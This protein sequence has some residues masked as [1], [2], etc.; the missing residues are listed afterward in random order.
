MK[1]LHT[2][3]WQLGRPYARIADADKRAKARAARFDALET[4]VTIAQDHAVSL[5]VV[6]GDV[7]DAPTVD[8]ATVSRACRALGAFGVPVVLLPGNHDHGAPGSVWHQRFFATE[9]E[10]LAPNVTVAL[11]SEPLLLGGA[12]LF[13]CPLL[14][15]S[16]ALD[17]T[18][19]LRDGS[20]L[21]QAP[22]GAPRIILAHGATQTFG[23]VTADDEDATAS[24]FIDL[25]RL[26]EHDYDYAALG[27]WHG[28]KQVAPKAWYAGTHEP[29]RFPRG[30]AYE[31]GQALVVEVARHK[32]P[33]VQ[34]VKSG[35]LQWHALHHA[36]HGEA[37]VQQ[38]A[39]AI[40]ARVGD[41]VDRHLLD[42]TL[43]GS[44]GL[45]GIEQ[46]DHLFDRLNARLVRLKLNN[47]LMLQPSPEELNRLVQ[48]HQDPTIAA[49]AASLADE[50]G[51]VGEASETARAALLELHRLISLA[52]KA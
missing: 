23:S 6:A 44:L 18:A 10:A 52:E 30:D 19:S 15:R 39:A 47:Q 32:A 26:P 21:N 27:D 31:T 49:V 50:T 45:T 1:I 8:K 12:A 41:D 4:L 3:D 13:P 11:T 37:D 24:N 38:L 51:A 14:R 46:L 5:V 7:F 16:E 28:T 9:C 2:A 35:Q 29:D 40:D 33:V 43:T 20:A 25:A 34:R 17:T 36:L 22:L 42:L 48:R